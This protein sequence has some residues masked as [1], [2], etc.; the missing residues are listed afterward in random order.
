MNITSAKDFYGKKV[1][2][3][4]LGLHGGGVSGAYWFFRQGAEV[5]ISDM[6]TR[7][8]LEP[9]IARLTA[10]CNTFRLA[11]PTARLFSLE[12]ILGKHRQEDVMRADIIIQNP[13][14]PREL[15]LLALARERGVPIHND[16]SIFFSLT[17]GIPVIGVTG[18][19]GKTTT[20]LLISELLKKKYPK[21]LVAGHATHEGAVSFFSILDKACEQSRTGIK[22]P[23]VLELSSWQLELLA[24]HHMSPLVAVVTNVYPDHLNR[25]ESMLEYGEA[26]KGIYRFQDSMW[27]DGG[28]VLNYD[29]PLTRAMGEEIE[30]QRQYWFSRTYARIQRGAF[31]KKEKTQKSKTFVT[32]SNDRDDEVCHCSDVP[33]KGE[34][35]EENV[36]AALAVGMIFGVAPLAMKEFCVSIQGVPGRLEYM[37]SRNGRALYNDTTSTSPDATRAALATLGGRSKKIVLIAGGSDKGL[38]FSGMGCAIARYCKALIMLSGTASPSIIKAADT[39]GYAGVIALANS[40]P[41]AVEKAWHASAKNDI[42]LLSP[43]AASFGMFQH[44]FDRGNQFISEIERLEDCA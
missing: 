33:L 32:R 22:A 14:V 42:I 1:L 16:A 17:R 15:P 43:G 2:M 5:I 44:E 30:P 31:L 38:D 41:E 39:A 28:V 19:R 7:P 18:T 34:H 27:H 8:Q 6:K 25:Y 26:K 37:G 13:G 21:T 24:E 35:N 20:I 4:G 23:V 40:M 9:S 10:L 11:H 12:Y 36:L 3:I 29:N